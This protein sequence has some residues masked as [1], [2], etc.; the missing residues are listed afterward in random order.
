LPEV[1]QRWLAGAE[2]AFDRIAGMPNIGSPQEVSNPA[3]AGLRA[4]P[5]PSFEDLRVY[6][7]ADDAKILVIRVLHDKRDVLG[8]LGGEGQEG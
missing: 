4:W 1:A 2:A 5:V 7:L 8:I 6:Y 3:F